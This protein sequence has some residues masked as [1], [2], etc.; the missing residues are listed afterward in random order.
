MVGDRLGPRRAKGNRD[1]PSRLVDGG[2][3]DKP[4]FLAS[5]GAIKE[6]VPFFG[7]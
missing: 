7:V 1:V 3:R 5:F 6:S 4:R 2:A